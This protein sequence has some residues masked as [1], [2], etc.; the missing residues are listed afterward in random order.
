MSINRR[1]APQPQLASPEDAR[2]NAVTP[3]PIGAE[4][5][6]ERLGLEGA[7]PEG[8]AVSLIRRNL[9]DGAGEETPRR[10]AHR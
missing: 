3:L 1:P 7:G 10:K 9:S 5:C 8:R 2:H 6:T 4:R